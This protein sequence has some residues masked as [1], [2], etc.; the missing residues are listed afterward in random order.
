[1]LYLL[2]TILCSTAIALILKRNSARKGDP[3]ILLA[4][5]Y[6][7]AAIVGAFFLAFDAEAEYSWESFLFGAGLGGMFVYTF[8]AF[9]K[10]VDYAGA[11]LASVSSRL[12]VIVPIALSVAIYSEI[13]NATQTVGIAL[14]LAVIVLFYFSLRNGGGKALEF[15]DLFYLLVLMFGIG[16]NDFCVKVF[17]HWR[18]I[19]EKPLFLFSIFLFAFIYITAYALIRR[20]KFDRNSFVLGNI[21]GVPNIFS[22]FFLILSLGALPAIVVYP[23]VNIGIIVL[24]AFAALILFK[25]KLNKFGVAALILGIIAIFLLSLR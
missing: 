1:M 21:L 22:S 19:E 18:P 25:E 5:N 14:A 3:I 6:L 11:S 12:S 16:I 13:P 15:K 4:G 8:F 20:I 17:T 24:T 23:A 7:T 2:L 9:T 10:A